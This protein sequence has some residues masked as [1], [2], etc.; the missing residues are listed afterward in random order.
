MYVYMYDPGA[1]KPSVFTRLGRLRV[2][3]HTKEQKPS[4]NGLQEYV[5]MEVFSGSRFE[6]FEVHPSIHTWPQIA[7]TMLNTQVSKLMHFALT[8][9][10]QTFC[11]DTSPIALYN[12]VHSIRV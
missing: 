11:P 9:D 1:P 12:I 3:P 7:A 6:V 4:P 8:S 10:V 5:F 2:L